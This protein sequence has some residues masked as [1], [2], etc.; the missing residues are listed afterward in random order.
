MKRSTLRHTLIEKRSSEQ[1]QNY[2]RQRNIC[3][4]ILKSAKK[5]FFENLNINE[6]TDNRNFWKTVKPFFTDRC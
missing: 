2:K 5:T 3:S 1:W 6:I 4:N